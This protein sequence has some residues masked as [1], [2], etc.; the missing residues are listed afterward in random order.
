M[1]ISVWFRW[2]YWLLIWYKIPTEK[3]RK[4]YQC[5]VLGFWMDYE[6]ELWVCVEW[7]RVYFLIGK[8]QIWYRKFGRAFFEKFHYNIFLEYRSCWVV[9]KMVG[10]LTAEDGRQWV[11]KHVCC[12][13]KW[14]RVS[15]KTICILLSMDHLGLC[16]WHW[17]W[18]IPL[19]IIM[20]MSID[21]DCIHHFDNEQF[22]IF[23]LVF[24]V[25]GGVWK[26]EKGKT[27]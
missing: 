16:C 22:V 27:E 21:L 14:E 20:E 6:C 11:F 23:I 9:L 4:G 18:E 13:M 3:S 2:K 8:E 5:G 24:W 7:N 25:Q 26:K 19:K 17:A 15:E 12:L 1:N 10:V